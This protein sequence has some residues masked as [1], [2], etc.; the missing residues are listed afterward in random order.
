MF[1]LPRMNYF[2]NPKLLALSIADFAEYYY[3][4]F[5]NS[6]ANAGIGKHS[7]ESMGSRKKYS[8]LKNVK[9]QS[10]Q[11]QSSHTIL[12]KPKETRLY[13]GKLH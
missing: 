1:P 7:I 4:I 13:Q 3:A 9:F 12:R 10:V 5:A 8:L 2:W 6:I 11:K